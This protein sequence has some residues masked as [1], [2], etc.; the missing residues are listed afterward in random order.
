[1]GKKT[2]GWLI[3]AAVL[4][5]LGAALFAVAMTAIKW[6]FSGLSTVTYGTNAHTL[7]A[8]IRDITVDTDTADIRFLPSEDGGCKVVCYEEDA[9][10]HK[11]EVKDGCLSIHLEDNR[12]WYDHIGIGFGS[13][14]ITVYL[15]A[16]DYGSLSV[17]GSTGD[18]DIPEHFSFSQIDV[19]LSTGHVTARASAAGHIRITAST[20]EVRLEEVTAGSVAIST[21]TG[22]ITVSGL[23]CTGTLEVDV[24]T[25]DTELRAV[26]CGS[27]RSDGSTGDLL[28]ADLIAGES[29]TVRRSTGKVTFDGCDGS[30]IT[31]E[32]DTG[33]VGGTLLSDKLFK[34]RTDTGDIRVPDTSSGGDC[35]VTTATGD[36]AL[37]IQ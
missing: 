28:M 27:F 30:Q 4:M 12:K 24:S 1:M 14:E 37:E 5:L 3:A 35:R 10:R 13:P 26:R 29:I 20:G 25:G 9:A 7:S 15:P 36:I 33:D 22:Q 32:T 11:V 21:S 2:K 34:I 31:V 8:D 19:Q 18:V 17:K 16:G 6:D 23:E